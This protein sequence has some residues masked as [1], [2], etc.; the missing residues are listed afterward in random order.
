MAK[1]KEQRNR[2]F[3]EDWQKG[4]SNEDLGEKYSLSPGG[5]KALKQRLRVKNSSLY[6]VTS[7]ST[8]TQT[9]TSTKRMTFW[10]PGEMIEKIKTKAK[11]EERTASQIARELFSKHL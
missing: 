4:F 9:S 3:I 7:P 8:S 2:L 6:K 11:K 5:V 10:L 1:P